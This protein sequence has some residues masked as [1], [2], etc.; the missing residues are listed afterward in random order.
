MYRFAEFGKR[1][2]GIFHDLMNPLNALIANMSQADKCPEGGAESK[3]YLLRA[4]DASRRMGELLGS[5]KK[6]ISTPLTEAV[7]SC[8]TEVREAITILNFRIARSGITV[9]MHEDAAVET[10]GSAIKFH[11]VAL[12]LI[13]NAIDACEDRHGDSNP[14]VTITL[15]QKDNNGILT[16]TDTGLGMAPEILS[17]IFTP[18][19]TTKS[20]TQGRGLGL[21]TTKEIVELDFHGTIEVAS[22]V[23]TGTTF[24][25]IFPLTHTHEEKAKIITKR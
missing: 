6:Q 9:H 20:R 1:S 11:Q 8:N 17:K 16:V 14:A 15:A 7:F 22:I 4:V 21:S 19:F 2:S 18:F 10:Y 25:I 23:G 5:I 12:N 24:T 3:K 13:A